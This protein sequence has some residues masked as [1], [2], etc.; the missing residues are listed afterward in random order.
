MTQNH[1]ITHILP[2]PFEWITIP[3]GDVTLNHSGGYILHPMKVN[4]PAFV[5]AKFPITNAQFQVFA[6]APDGFTNSAWWDFSDS[7]QEWRLENDQPQKP[8]GGDNHPRT[9]ITWFEAVAF[10]RWLTD[11]LSRREGAETLSDK[12]ALP[13]ES[14]WQRAAQGDNGRL[15][16]WGNEWDASRCNNNTCHDRIGTSPVT[17]YAGLGDSLFGV[18]DLVGNVWEW[19][20]TSWQTGA[21]DMGRDDVRVLRGGSWFDDIISH[22]RCNFRSS[23]NP[24]I[25]SDL[26][27]FRIVRS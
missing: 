15:Y 22:F 11:T 9:H 24:G 1:L 17:E 18:V 8:Y 23:W 7:A 19:C 6:D 2:P 14:Q 26:R 5:I 25:S 12:I 27:G 16:P 21:D 4:V 20:L 13:T 10:C 3:G